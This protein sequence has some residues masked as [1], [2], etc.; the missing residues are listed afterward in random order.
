MLKLLINLFFPEVCYACLRFL[1]DN[2]NCICTHCRHHLPVTNFHFT[3]SDAI[4]KVLYGRAVIENGT[5]LFRFEKKGLV[6]QLIHGL[7][8]KGYQKIGFTLGNWLGAELKTVQAYKN[9]DLVI[10]VPLHKS[11][12]KKRGYNQVSKF[13]QQIAQAINATYTDKILLKTSQSTSQVNKKRWAR[14]N[15][16]NTL[17]VLN[18][19]TKIDNK[20]IL[21]VD[22]VITTGATLEAC[23]NVL[24]QA[25]NVK[26]SIATIA[27]A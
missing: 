10:P 21:I 9:I 8:Y 27:I 5:A 3:N 6:Q 1:S 25:N 15:N 11:K 26:I 7:K 4:K 13:A 14:W 12:L 19:K 18:N 16:T 17:F 23:I 20:H 22:D 2:E 24:Q